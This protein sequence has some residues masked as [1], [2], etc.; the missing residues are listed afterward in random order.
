MESSKQTIIVILI[1]F[2]WGVIIHVYYSIVKYI[3]YFFQCENLSSNEH[4]LYFCYQIFSRIAFE[5]YH[6]EHFT[7]IFMRT[8]SYVRNKI[9][10]RVKICLNDEHQEQFLNRIIW[11][12]RSHFCDEKFKRYKLLIIMCKSLKMERK[13]ELILRY[14]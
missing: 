10:R 11:N 13:Y 4:T 5:T 12:I 7:Y 9:I 14:Y 6:D 3:R 8:F 2:Y 1:L